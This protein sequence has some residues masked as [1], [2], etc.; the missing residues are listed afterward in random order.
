MSFYE[1]KG[2][3]DHK[4]ED[5]EWFFNFQFKG[6][7]KYTEWI[8]DTDTKCEEV[9]SAY[10]ESIGINT[11]H[12]FCRVSTK[13]QG[14]PQHI[15]LHAQ[16]KYLRKTVRDIIGESTGETKEEKTPHRVKVHRLCS[17][18]Y[19][20]VPTAFVD[21]VDAARAGD[22]VITYRVDRLS[23]NIIKYL[24]LLEELDEKGVKIYSKDENIWYRGNKVDFIQKILDGQRES[25]GISKRVRTSLDYRRERGDETFGSTKYGF[26]IS[27]SEEDGRVMVVESLSE[28]RIIKF[29]KRSK[30]TFPGAIAEK[31][32]KTNRLKRGKLWTASM[33]K[34]IL[35]R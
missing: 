7:G 2:V 25:Q 27:R 32:N 10:L 30:G 23:R 22:I 5:G 33:V 3:I 14:D 35:N 19:K 8:K 13:K 1:V 16:E 17:S 21:I 26:M 29:I 18:A 4:I 15:S 20:S 9:I 24:A 28:Q 12:L 31:L 34:A 11:V 6:Y